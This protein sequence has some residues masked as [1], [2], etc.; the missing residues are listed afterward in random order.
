MDMAFPFQL[1]EAK[2]EDSII[3]RKNHEKRKYVH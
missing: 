3:E 2:E 1:L